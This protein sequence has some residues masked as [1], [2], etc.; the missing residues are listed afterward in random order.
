MSLIFY[1][2]DG[3]H[4]CE[5]ALAMLSAGGLAKGLRLVDIDDDLSLGIEFGLRIP[6]IANAGGE[7]LDWPF[8]LDQARA[9]ASK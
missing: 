9:L 5:Q 7:R 1:H 6:V 2:R 3:C 4:L 8:E